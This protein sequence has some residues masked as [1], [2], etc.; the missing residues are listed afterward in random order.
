MSDPPEP[1]LRAGLVS[2]PVGAGYQTQVL[3]KS[4][5]RS[6]LLSHLSSSILLLLRQGLM[7][8]RLAKNS[9]RTE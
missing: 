7:S 2:L 8:S 6:E 5:Q 4:G 9:L 3:C 1:E